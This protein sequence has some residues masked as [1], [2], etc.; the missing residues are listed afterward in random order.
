MGRFPI[1]GTTVV[2]SNHEYDPVADWSGT[3]PVVRDEFDSKE[4][5]DLEF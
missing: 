5:L 2:S 1:L 4:A 3:D